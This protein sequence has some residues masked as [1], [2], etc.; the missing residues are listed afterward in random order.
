MGQKRAEKPHFWRVFGLFSKGHGKI[1]FKFELEVALT[2]GSNQKTMKARLEKMDAPF[3]PVHT[4]SLE[5]GR[6]QRVTYV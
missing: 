4:P 2:K 6:I 3:L 5:K 1:C